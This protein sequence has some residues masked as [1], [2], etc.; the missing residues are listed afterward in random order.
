MSLEINESKLRK[1][2]NTDTSIVVDF[3]QFYD[4]F[5]RMVAVDDKLYGVDIALSKEIRSIARECEEL[6]EWMEEY[7]T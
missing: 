3:E 5:Q 4:L 7:L 2:I 6:V 1:Y